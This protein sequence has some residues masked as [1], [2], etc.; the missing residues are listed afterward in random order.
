MGSLKQVPKHKEIAKDKVH[1]ISSG[2]GQILTY[3][4]QDT[5]LGNL[6][7]NYEPEGDN[8]ANTLTCCATLLDI[9]PHDQHQQEAQTWS[10]KFV[11]QPWRPLNGTQA[12]KEILYLLL[13]YFRPSNA[14]PCFNLLGL[15]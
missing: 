10:R 5:C 2:S 14:D 12:N 9:L 8:A 1:Q 3:L 6:S 15:I 4:G 11:V 13:F 7:C